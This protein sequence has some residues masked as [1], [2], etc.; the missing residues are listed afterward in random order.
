[1]AFKYVAHRLTMLTLIAQCGG[2]HGSGYRQHSRLPSGW[3][4]K[5]TP[6]AHN[7]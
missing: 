7:G 3:R 6:L 1:V 5:L 2:L 4:N